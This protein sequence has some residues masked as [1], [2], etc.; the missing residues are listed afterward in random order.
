MTTIVGVQYEW[1]AVVGSDMQTTNGDY[2]P[3]NGPA[4]VKQRRVGPYLVACSGAG[5]ACD[6]TMYRWKPPDPGKRSGFR[7]IVSHVVPS[8]A[9]ARKAA[10]CE[11]AELTTLLVLGGDLFHIESDGTVLHHERG[12]YGIGSGS[13]Y[14]IGALW[15]G[16]SVEEA[17]EVA[18]ANDAYTSGPFTVEECRRK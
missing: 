7:F 18:A 6:V 12:I 1:G 8:L 9:A 14:A 17:L 2:R 4:M 3:Y 15:V 11:E 5:A 13:A 16:A 10:D